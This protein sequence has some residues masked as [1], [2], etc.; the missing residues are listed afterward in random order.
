LKPAFHT[1][2]EYSD[3]WVDDARLVLLNAQGVREHGGTIYTRTKVISGSRKDGVWHICLEDK[4][5]GKTR[6]VTSKSLVNAAG[7]WVTEVLSGL[8]EKSQK[9]V[10]LVK[11]SHIIVP[12][13]YQGEQA[14]ILQN[15]DKRVVFIIPFL[16]NYSL[17]GT[18]EVDYTGDPSLAACSDEERE[19]LCQVVNDHFKKTVSV[20]DIIWEYSGVRP[21]FEDKSSD[22]RTATRDYSFEF[23][24]ENGKA[25]LISVFG[26]KLTTYR[27]L[28][29]HAMGRMARYFPTA[30]GSW[31]GK[32]FL[33]GAQRADQCLHELQ[34]NYPWLPNSI[35]IRFVHSYGSLTHEFLGEMTR[36]RDLGIHFGS[37]LYQCEVDYLIHKEWVMEADDL[38]WRRSKLGLFLS[39][40]ESGVL[41]DYIQSSVQ[42]ALSTGMLSRIT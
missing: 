28:A 13:I 33:P 35:A 14:Y 34:K 16:G 3:V 1:V 25:P 19:Y 37:G 20:E 18:T 38:L 5:T 32:H 11:G 8:S 31:T 42:R 26:G 4:I 30:T 2:F 21:L 17:I 40:E 9:R 29:E 27:K 36:I 7:P 41:A 6:E 24:D 12:A 10:R 23:E 39:A 22:A 15:Y